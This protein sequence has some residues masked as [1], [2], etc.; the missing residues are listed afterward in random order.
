MATTVVSFLSPESAPMRRLKEEA[1]ER[2]MPITAT[3]AWRMRPIIIT[4]GG[5]VLLSAVQVVTLTQRF[6]AGEDA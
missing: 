6:Y 2:N 5:H 4:A 3:H 1:G